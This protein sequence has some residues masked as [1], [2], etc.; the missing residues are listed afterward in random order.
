LGLGVASATSDQPPLN[1]LFFIIYFLK[2]WDGGILEKKKNVRM[3]KLQKF[4]S[5]RG[6]I[7]KIETLKVKLK[8]APN[9]KEV[10]CNFPYL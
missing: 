2:T 6:C 8:I 5:L 10:K 4:R 9:F 3:V 7:A 1:F